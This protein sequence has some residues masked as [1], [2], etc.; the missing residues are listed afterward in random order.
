MKRS[1]WSISFILS[2]HIGIVSAGANL[3]LPTSLNQWGEVGLLQLPS[4]RFAEAGTL[5]FGLAHTKFYQHYFT[6]LQNFPWL[7]SSLSYTQF[8]PDRSWNTR[9]NTKIRL[10]QE[11]AYLPQVAIGIR[12]FHKF[13]G[14]DKLAGEYLV[15]SKQYYDW[16]F[17]LGLGWGYFATGISKHSYNSNGIIH[18]NAWLHGTRAALFAGAR[19]QT[20]IPGLALKLELDPNDH[21]YEAHDNHWLSRSPINVG[22]TYRPKTGIDLSIGMSGGD[23]LLAQA[24][25]YTNTHRPTVPTQSTQKQRYT[26]SRTNPDALQ[27]IVSDLKQSGFDSDYAQIKHQTLTIQVTRPNLTTTPQTLGRVARVAS[28]YLSEKVVPKLHYIEQKKGLAT[29]SVMLPRWSF[30]RAITHRGSPEEVWHHTRLIPPPANLMPA[31][32]TDIAYPNCAGG[33]IV[34]KLLQHL[35][36]GEQHYYYQFQAQFSALCQLTPNWSLSGALVFNISDNL[37]GL[38]PSSALDTRLAA[39]RQDRLYYTSHGVKDLTLNYQWKPNTA[40]YA[41]SSIGLLEDMYAGISTEFLYQPYDQPWAFG[42]D[43]HRVRKR[44]INQLIDLQDYQTTTGHLSGY[45]HIASRN[46]DIKLSIGRYLA[47]DIGATLDISHHFANGAQVGIYTTISEK[48]DI[49]YHDRGI[50][51]SLPLTPLQTTHAQLRYQFLTHNHGQALQHK[52]YPLTRNGTAVAIARD[53]H[54]LL[55]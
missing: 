26:A 50:Y 27:S 44:G 52:L 15:A 48:S 5:S 23:T 16:D 14:S 3:S 42:V 1:L 30:S 12:N 40:W 37:S 9:L 8:K 53:W 25:L 51:L 45:Y 11:S 47:Q 33:S 22:L 7:E 34:P 39:V 10:H 13:S 32:S 54:S 38:L 49:H 46:L 2:L 19:Y 55:D 29:S 18:T 43:L 41:Y 4:A 24:T 21:R 36:S 6:T 17:T 35:A 31:E 28:R 20:D